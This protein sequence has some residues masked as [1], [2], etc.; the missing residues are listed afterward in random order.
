MAFLATFWFYN[1]RESL[2][3]GISF[4][5]LHMDSNSS[6]GSSTKCNI[7]YVLP[8]PTNLLNKQNFTKSQI[9]FP[10]IFFS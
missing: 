8:A 5:S 10:S 7:E 4:L 6:W 1:W 2:L 9:E 3:Q